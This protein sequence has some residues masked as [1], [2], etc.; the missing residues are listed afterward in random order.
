MDSGHCLSNNYTLSFAR[1]LARRALITARPP[2]VFI[3]ARKP[4]VRLR[5]T[6]EG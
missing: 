6:T 3:R 4:W 5:L 2:L 1:P